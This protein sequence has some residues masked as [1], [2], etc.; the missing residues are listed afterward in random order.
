MFSLFGS[1]GLK[2]S[3]VPFSVPFPS[4]LPLPATGRDGGGERIAPDREFRECTRV[5]RL[6]VL[7]AIREALREAGLE[8]ATITAPLHIAH[9]TAEDATDN[10]TDTADTTNTA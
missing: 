6:R 9:C 5:V 3:P 8:L 7:E 2:S 10:T 1:Q 4:P